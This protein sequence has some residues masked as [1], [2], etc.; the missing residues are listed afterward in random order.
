[1]LKSGLDAHG[2]QS[3]ILDGHKFP[4]IVSLNQCQ[5]ILQGGRRSGYD[6]HVQPSYVKCV[7]PRPGPSQLFI[8]YLHVDNGFFSNNCI[9]G[10][11]I[12]SIGLTL[13]ETYANSNLEGGLDELKASHILSGPFRLE[14]TWNPSEHLTF[15]GSIGRPVVRVLHL[16]RILEIY[17]AQRAGL[18][19]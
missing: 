18:A 17:I 5:W 1:M 13:T 2:C 4:D 16:D 9:R 6:F 19:R 12:R 8:S 10:E 15:S 14:I 3:E 11:F 7:E